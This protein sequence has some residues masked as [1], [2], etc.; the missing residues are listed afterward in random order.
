[1]KGFIQ[2]AMVKHPS[3]NRLFLFQ[4]PYRSVKVGDEVKVDTVNGIQKGKV[5][6]EN[7]F[8]LES[9]MDKIMRVVETNGATWPLKRIV[10][11]LEEL[12][13]DWEKHEREQEA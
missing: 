3:D 10:S 7:D 2:I 9:G 6:F 8:C 13:V 4:A 1:M 12:P 11:V 5:M